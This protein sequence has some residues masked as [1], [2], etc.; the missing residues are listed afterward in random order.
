MK[1]V[2]QL[3]LLAVVWWLRQGGAPIVAGHCAHRCGR[4]SIPYPF[5]LERQCA[6]SKEF[7]LNCTTT[8]GSGDQLWLGNTPIRK[9]SFGDS[10]MVISI[11]ELHDCYNETGRVNRSDYLSIDLSSY[12]QYRFSATRNALTVLG[13]DTY[14]LTNVPK[15]DVYDFSRGG[16]ISYCSE[17]VDLAKE[18]TCSGIGCCQAS[19]PK[20]L[21]K[22][23]IRIDSF[24][25]HKNVSS[26]SPCGVAFVGDKESFNLSS[27]RLP[28]LNDLGKRADLVLDWMIGWDVTCQ[29]ARYQS[30]YGCGNNTDCRDFADAPGY[31]C[32]CQHGYEGNPYNLSRGGCQDINECEDPQKYPCRGKCENLPGSYRCDSDGDNR[33][34][35]ALASKIRKINFKRNRGKFFKSQGVQIFTEAELAK[36]TNNYDESKKLGE[37]SFGSV[38]KGRVAVGKSGSDSVNRGRT[39]M[40]IEVAVKKPKDMHKPLMKKEFQDELLTV[41]Q[42][43]HKN[44]VKLYGICLETRIPLLVYE[45]I[46]NDTHLNTLFKHIH[47]EVSTFLRSWENRL[48]IATE[49]TL[50]LKEMHSNETIHGNIKSAN[51]LIDQN[52]SVK[53][54]DFGISVLK[55]LQ[56][57]HI[58]ATEIEG[59]LDY[60]DPEYLT[61][62][63]LTIKSDVYNFGAVLME[64]LTGK[65]PTSFVANKSEESIS[66]IPHFI[67]SVNDGTLFNV[68]NFKAVGED[69]IKQVEVVAKIAA[70]CLDQSSRKRP[71]MSEVAQQLPPINQ[72]LMV[73]VD[74]AE[75]KFEEA[76]NCPEP[77]FE[78]ARICPTVKISVTDCLSCLGL[79]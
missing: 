14:A 33:R 6:R 22:L 4:V 49:A 61:T 47:L 21:K 11:P 68:I 59:T 65:K 63:K 20:G 34:D 64:L 73:P 38:Y 56:H 16:C 55:S 26:F 60:I 19:I 40:D 57:S 50:A 53:I 24:N 44:M 62:G 67:S 75:P 74:N 69:E 45:Y 18:T 28:T 23:R 39:T 71:T 15:A 1:V 2:Q 76:R 9:I 52:Y 72:S 54:S 29:R 41:M 12:P 10:T 3:L 43:N 79:D 31:R 32:F 27:R 78:E 48:K 66:I 5:G 51:I 30:S 36:A 42:T 35:I 7:L 58:V 37:G 77:K 25:N 13:C 46:L 70:K 17:Y 8:D